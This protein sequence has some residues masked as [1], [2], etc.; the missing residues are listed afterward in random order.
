MYLCVRG[1]DFASFYDFSIVFWKCSHSVIFFS[2]LYSSSF[3]LVKMAEIYCS[4]KDVKQQSI[5]QYFLSEVKGDRFT[6]MEIHKK[7]H[8]LD[9]GFKR[10]NPNHNL[11]FTLKETYHLD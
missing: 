7:L 4:I 1:I 8:C 11:S 9:V 5:Y 10:Y 6:F 3:S 2:S